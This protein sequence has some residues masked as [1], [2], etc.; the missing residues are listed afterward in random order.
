MSFYGITSQ[1]G[2]GGG[3]RLGIRPSG[4]GFG[5]TTDSLNHPGGTAETLCASVSSRTD[6]VQHLSPRAVR[7]RGEAA[8]GFPVTPKGLVPGWTVAGEEVPVQLQAVV[9]D[10]GEEGSAGRSNLRNVIPVLSSC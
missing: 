2:R 6:R 10:L 7:T 8:T 9:R 1:E 4:L 5:C 3:H